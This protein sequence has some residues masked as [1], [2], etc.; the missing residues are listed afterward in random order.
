MARHTLE[1]RKSAVKSVTART[2]VEVKEVT[3]YQ[4]RHESRAK[5][6]L[7]SIHASMRGCLMQL[8]LLLLKMMAMTARW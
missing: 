7:I 8:V 5:S 6:M 1:C 2:S 4:L 3:N